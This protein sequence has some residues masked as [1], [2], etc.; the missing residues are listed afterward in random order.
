MNI[1]N[2]KQSVWLGIEAIDK[3]DKY[4][5]KI[6]DLLSVNNRLNE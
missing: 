3:K 2:G 4:M 1:Q 6:V 5:I